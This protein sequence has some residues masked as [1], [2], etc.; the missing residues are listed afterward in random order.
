MSTRLDRF[1]QPV[2]LVWGSADR[3]FKLDF[4][5]RLR[6]TFPNARMTEV[7]GGRTFLPLDEPDVVADAIE[8]GLDVRG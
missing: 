1:A 7:A 6:D 2:A 3:F 8:A 4:A 5:H